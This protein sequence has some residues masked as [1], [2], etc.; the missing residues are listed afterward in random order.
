MRYAQDD[1]LKK[2][3]C[4]ITTKTLLQHPTDKKLKKV[5]FF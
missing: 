2:I 5:K 4:F 1:L 3:I